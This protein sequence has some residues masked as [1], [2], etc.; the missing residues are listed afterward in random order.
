MKA[1]NAIAQAFYLSPLYD[2]I[3]VETLDYREHPVLG[4]ISSTVWNAYGQFADNNSKLVDLLEQKP[5]FTE[6]VLIRSDHD[7]EPGL[8]FNAVP[9]LSIVRSARATL[10]QA[11]LLSG[12]GRAN[13]LKGS[14][15][16]DVLIGWAG[17][18]RLEGGWGDDVLAGGDDADRFVFRSPGSGAVDQSDVIVDFRGDDGD[19]IAVKSATGRVS[20]RF[21]GQSGDVVVSTWVSRVVLEPGEVLRPWM[22]QG[23]QLSVD[24]DGDRVG[25][26]RIDLPGVI[27]FNPD[28]IRFAR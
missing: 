1:V 7:A 28:W 4:G 12:D 23:T 5:V 20:N 6:A 16:A 10:D 11:G 21:S 25:D 24:W 15:R 14:N 26:Q 3:E 22:I 8:G 19:R 9:G 2:A 13:R 17:Q 27:D 18:D